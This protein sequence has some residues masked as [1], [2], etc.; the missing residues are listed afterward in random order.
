MPSHRE[1]HTRERI[2]GHSSDTYEPSTHRS[3]RSSV[4]PS[5]QSF[6]S[7]YETAREDF[8]RSS[9]LRKHGVRQHRSSRRDKSKYDEPDF[10]DVDSDNDS[11]AASSNNNTRHRTGSSG[12][13]SHRAKKHHSE[14]RSTRRGK[15]KDDESNFGDLDSEATSVAAPSTSN[16]QH[17]SR[18]S[19]LHGPINGG[20]LTLD[21]VESD[22]KSVAA[23]SSHSSANDSDDRMANFMNGYTRAP[24]S[25]GSR[26]RTS[27]RSSSTSNR[28]SPLG[29]IDSNPSSIG[30]RSSAAQE[31]TPESS[32]YSESGTSSIATTMYSFKSRDSSVAR[33][34]EGKY[35]NRWSGKAPVKIYKPLTQHRISQMSTSKLIKKS[36]YLHAESQK[37]SAPFT[38]ADNDTL[39]L[40]LLMSW[41]KMIKYLERKPHAENFK[42]DKDLQNFFRQAE[43]LRYDLRDAQEENEEYP[44]EGNQF[45]ELLKYKVAER[46]LIKARRPARRSAA[47]LLGKDKRFGFND[48]EEEKAFQLFAESRNS[49][50]KYTDS[51]RMLEEVNNRREG[52]QQREGRVKG[53]KWMKRYTPARGKNYI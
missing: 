18:S 45:K 51:R 17:R 25:Y 46:H 29:E 12:L 39:H 20:N 47:R 26:G 35:D 5:K 9:S 40:D 42:Y 34:V 30:T 33:L 44:V 49:L 8:P 10:G 41:V 21:D 19:G 48:Y 6:V 28:S 37:Y 14:S 23:F 15:S 32:V 24:E 43:N 22:R 7:S 27:H 50:Y 2:D 38:D 16:V 31:S 13:R 52:N 53:K 3:K 11:V 4:S 1:P 36:D